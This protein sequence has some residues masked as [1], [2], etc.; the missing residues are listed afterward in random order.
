MNAGAS[1]RVRLFTATSLAEDS[2]IAVALPPDLSCLLT[3][4]KLSFPAQPDLSSTPPSRRSPANTDIETQEEVFRRRTLIRPKNVI[5]LATTEGQYRLS[6]SQCRVQPQQQQQHVQ[7]HAQQL[8]ECDFDTSKVADDN[9]CGAAVMSVGKSGLAADGLQCDDG[10][11]AETVEALEYL[12][13]PHSM[14]FTVTSLDRR[15]NSIGNV[16]FVRRVRPPSSVPAPPAAG[17]VTGSVDACGVGP[18]EHAPASDTNGLA[19]AVSTSVMGGLLLLALGAVSIA[20]GFWRRSKARSAA[21]VSEEELHRRAIGWDW[22]QQQAGHEQPSADSDEG[23]DAL[24]LPTLLQTSVHQS[25]LPASTPAAAAPAV[26]AT[27]PPT[28]IT[29][30]ADLQQCTPIGLS[31]GIMAKGTSSAVPRIGGS[32]NGRT[33]LCSPVVETRAPAAGYAIA[34]S[35]LGCAT[36]GAAAVAAARLPPSPLVDSGTASATVEIAIEAIPETD[37]QWRSMFD[38]IYSSGPSDA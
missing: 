34:L 22:G 27:A 1:H 32:T 11:P 18:P 14:S 9:T 16:H 10:G 7:P 15:A 12:P 23:E 33:T 28:A 25:L 35:P 6:L 29:R 30:P 26:L 8:D 4:E 20:A 19:W 21:P 2:A 37:D 5:S 36:A 17:T 38:A 13:V 24:L 31:Q 3:L